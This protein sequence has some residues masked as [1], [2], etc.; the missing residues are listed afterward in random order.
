MQ[1]AMVH[2]MRTCFATMARTGRAARRN[3]AKSGGGNNAPSGL[4]PAKGGGPNDYVY[5][6]TSRANPEHWS[7]L[8]KLIGREELLEDPRFATGNDRVDHSVEL[9]AIIG[10]WTVKHEKREA[11]EKL[12]AV[13]VPSGAVFDTMELQNEPTFEERGF[14][15]TVTHHNG[16][17]YKMASWP[18]RIDG[19]TVQVK[20]SP[21][22]GGNTAEVLQSWL[23]LSE[24]D[25]AALKAEKVI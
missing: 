20:G 14:M 6:T 23:G 5:L 1:D 4:Y 3:G 19:K 22:P 13:G 12:I 21:A 25:Q 11:M 10:E 24:G 18:V 8:C 2:Y 16:G 15:Q 9:D 17:E 7:R